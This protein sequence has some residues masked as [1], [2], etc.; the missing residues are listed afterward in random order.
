MSLLYAKGAKLDGTAPCFI[1]GYGAYGYARD[2]G[3][4]ANSLSLADRGFVYAI[5]HVRG[6]TDKGWRWYA[7]GKLAN[8]P[9]TFSDFIAATEFLLAQKIA[10]PGAVVAHGGSAGGMMMGAIANLA[11]ALYAGIIEIGRAHV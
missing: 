4:N 5:A 8:K 11:P 10:R 9:N 7:G 3:F 6:G 2:A 1:T